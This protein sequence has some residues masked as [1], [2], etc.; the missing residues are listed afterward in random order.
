M[1]HNCTESFQIF[2]SKP[3]LFYW[4]LLAIQVGEE[5]GA[6]SPIEAL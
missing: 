2:S 6:L 4:A 3:L 1:I 5:V